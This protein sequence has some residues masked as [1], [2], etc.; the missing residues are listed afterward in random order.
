MSD[1]MKDRKLGGK[2]E[3]QRKHEF[4]SRAVE[5]ALIDRVC[6]QMAEEGC[7]RCFW[8]PASTRTLAREGSSDA[9]IY[10]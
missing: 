4:S 1:A 6:G 9:S 8:V 3:E 2:L 10:G 5:V 7:L